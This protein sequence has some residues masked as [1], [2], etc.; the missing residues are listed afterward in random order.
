MGVTWW[1]PRWSIFSTILCDVLGVFVWL[2][3]PAGLGDFR[4]QSPS[5]RADGK[6]IRKNFFFKSGDAVAQSAQGGGGVTVCG[7][8]QE[9]WRCGTEGRGQWAWWG[10]AGMVT[11]MLFSSLHGSIVLC[12]AHGGCA[13]PSLYPLWAFS[14][15]FFLRPGMHLQKNPFKS[16]NCDAWDYAISPKTVGQ[17]GFYVLVCLHWRHAATTITPGTESQHSIDGFCRS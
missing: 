1:G 6:D 9:Q 5:L 4:A 3:E 15:C 10:W 13:A 14:F 7:G 16:S 12:L 17:M 8:V 2:Q 11:P